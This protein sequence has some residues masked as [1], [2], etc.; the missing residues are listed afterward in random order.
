MDNSIL[1]GGGTIG[2]SGNSNDYV[3]VKSSKKI[4]VKYIPPT[5][6]SAITRATQTCNLTTGSPVLSNVTNTNNIEIGN[7]VFGTNIQPGTRVEQI[8]INQFL[9]LNKPTGGS[10]SQTQNLTFIDHR[11]L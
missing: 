4:D 9:V 7:Y 8:S 3:K 2:S 11:G 6:L 10:G 1:F 5:S